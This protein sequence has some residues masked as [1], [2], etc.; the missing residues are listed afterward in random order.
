[1][2]KIGQEIFLRDW[3]ELNTFEK[4]ER[5]KLVIKPWLWWMIGGAIGTWT[6]FIAIEQMIVRLVK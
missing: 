6:V 2:N 1:M 3:K 5:V 4:E